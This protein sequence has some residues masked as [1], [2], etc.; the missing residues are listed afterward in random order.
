MV[1]D[2]KILVLGFT[3]KENCAD[4][5]NTKVID[6]ISTLKE[7]TNDITVFDPYVDVEKIEKVFSFKILSNN[8]Q[9]LEKE[10]DVV[11]LAVSHSQ[12]VGL[13]PRKFLRISNGV[14]YD[15]K[16]FFAKQLIDGRL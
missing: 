6:I 4:I 13:N 10:F 8:I 14:V 11:I 16:S 9:H 12:F 7:Y 3:F 1:K 2:S 5:R 15:V